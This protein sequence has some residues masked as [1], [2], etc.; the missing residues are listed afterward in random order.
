MSDIKCVQVSGVK[1]TWKI[2]NDDQ[3]Q[4]EE[5]DST[6][7]YVRVNPIC[8]SLVSIVCDGNDHSPS[9]LPKGYSLTR[10]IGLNKLIK[11]RN[12]QQ[13]ADL[14]KEN[15]TL[16]GCTLFGEDD[17]APKAKKSKLQKEAAKTINQEHASMV[18]TLEL[19]SGP[20]CVRVL[21]PV[22]PKDGLFV[23]YNPADLGALITYLRDEGFDEALAVAKDLQLPKGVVKRGHSFIVKY[24]KLD[25]ST[26]FKTCHSIEDAVAFQANP[27]EP[28]YDDPA[29]VGG[30]GDDEDEAAIEVVR[31]LAAE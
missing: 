7:C 13:V 21:R 1:G 10:S 20:A 19:A 16:D 5:G 31:N 26:G 8:R 11:I 3:R 9:P 14:E 22:H 27:S 6:V 2:I 17:K 24:V 18:L 15:E 29:A 12:S 25:G 4:V 28:L 30:A 23:L